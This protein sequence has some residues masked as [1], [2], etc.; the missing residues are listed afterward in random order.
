MTRKFIYNLQNS[1]I[2]LYRPS[3]FIYYHSIVRNKTNGCEVKVEDSYI[4]KK[5]WDELCQLK[6]EL[7]YLGEYIAHSEKCDNVIN[8]MTA[9]T[10]SSSI[11][12]WALWDS[13]KFVWSF[14]I[15]FSQ[16]INA[17]KIHLPYSKRI[18]LLNQQ[19]SEL[20]KLFIDYDFLWLNISNG[21]FTDEEINENIRKFRIRKEKINDK[22]LLHNHLPQ[23]RK[24]IVKADLSREQY[25]SQ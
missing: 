24:L 23:K 15:A 25:Y 9:I 4:Q 1:V 18:K 12:A 5:Y 19:C 16:V 8:I 22:F 17:I 3:K 2:I 14:I 20:S 10:S 21:D 7:F 11:A 13:L 6:F